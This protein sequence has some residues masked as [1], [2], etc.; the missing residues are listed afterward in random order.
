MVQQIQRA[1]V[2]IK[3]FTVFAFLVLVVLGHQQLAA[4]SIDYVGMSFSP[5]ASMVGGSG[6]WT[7]TDPVAGGS[8]VTFGLTFT[9]NT[10][11]GTTTYPRTIGFGAT[12]AAKPAGAADAAVSG[13]WATTR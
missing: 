5:S 12:T 13:P 8:D 9:I 11:G 7:V 3:K 10:M 4:H 1:A 2:R 6:H